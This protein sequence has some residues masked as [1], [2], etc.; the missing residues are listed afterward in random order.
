MTTKSRPPPDEPKNQRTCEMLVQREVGHCVSYLIHHFAKNPNAL[1]G[2]DYTWEDDV[3]PL[4]SHDDWQSTWEDYQAIGEVPIANDLPIDDYREACEQAGIDEPFRSEAYEHW[5]VSEW[6]GSKLAA[7]GEM[8]GNLFGLTIWGR[9]TTG[10][11]IHLD[12]VII[13]IAH[14]MEILTGQRYEWTP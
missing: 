14:Q 11:A 8:V 10:Q 5:L 6:F 9:C 12:S 4:C 7:H 1:K 3:L 13:S 2:S